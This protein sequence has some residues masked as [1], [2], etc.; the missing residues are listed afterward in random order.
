[1]PNE[2]NKNV[3]IVQP[4]SWFICGTIELVKYAVVLK[5]IYSRIIQRLYK[6]CYPTKMVS[7][8]KRMNPKETVNSNEF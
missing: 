5:Y 3:L 7:F 2:I 4:I 6:L 8:N 1:M